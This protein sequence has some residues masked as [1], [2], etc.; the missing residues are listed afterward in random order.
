MEMKMKQGQKP[1]SALNIMLKAVHPQLLTR[2]KLKL[3]TEKCAF[4]HGQIEDCGV[5]LP[6]ITLEEMQTYETMFPRQANESH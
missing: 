4:C 3:T 6:E 2:D 1:N 5:G